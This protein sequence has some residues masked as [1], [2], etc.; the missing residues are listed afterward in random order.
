VLGS[1]F[2]YETGEVYDHFGSTSRN[3][4]T[5][6]GQGLDPD[7]NPIPPVGPNCDTEDPNVSPGCY[8]SQG[9]RFTGTY[10]GRGDF[11]FDDWWRLDVSARYQIQLWRNLNFWFKVD[12]LNFTNQSRLTSF[13]TTGFV[14]TS[15]D[16]GQW[17][18]S[19]SFGRIRNDSDY[20]DARTWLFT[21]GLQF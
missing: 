1:V 2:T 20:Q 19:S 3:T 16:F 15:G 14:D 7:G 10:D 8:V 6:A 9:G 18:P 11:N 21:V 13:Q 5:T 17:Q 12:A 4:N